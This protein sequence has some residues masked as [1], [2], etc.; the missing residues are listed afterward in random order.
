MAIQLGLQEDVQD[1]GFFV[2]GPALVVVFDNRHFA[3]AICNYFDL[4]P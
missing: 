2:N 3:V 1:H 4:H